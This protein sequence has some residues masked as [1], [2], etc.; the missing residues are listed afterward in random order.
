MIVIKA[1]E[2][3]GC[4]SPERSLTN[5]ENESVTS[6][7]CDGINYTYYQGDEI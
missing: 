1:I 3:N 5:E 4:L 7:S 2:I 6:S